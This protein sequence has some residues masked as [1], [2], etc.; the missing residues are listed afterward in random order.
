MLTWHATW[1]HIGKYLQKLRA[2]SCLF[3]LLLPLSP[4]LT[5]LSPFLMAVV[6]DTATGGRQ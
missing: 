3:H 2:P 4:S 1:C 6:A 5:Y